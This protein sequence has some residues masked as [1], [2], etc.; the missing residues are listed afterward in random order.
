MLVLVYEPVVGVARGEQV[1]RGHGGRH[2]ALDEPYRLLVLLPQLGEFGGV[3]DAAAVGFA[4]QLHE[5]RQ[6]VG[7]QVLELSAAEVGLQGGHLLLAGQRVG[8]VV[9]LEAGGGAVAFALQLGLGLHHGE[10]VGGY[11]L[12]VAPGLVK[13]VDVAELAF[14]RQGIYEGDDGDRHAEG[15]D[16]VVPVPGF[17]PFFSGRH[18]SFS[19]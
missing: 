17:T 9:R 7:R 12:L 19:V 8:G 13:L 2:L 15:Q 4:Q 18:S 1:G 6:V 11:E 16:G 5:A 10:V 14:A 3:D